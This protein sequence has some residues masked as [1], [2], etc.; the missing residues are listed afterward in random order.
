MDLRRGDWA[1]RVGWK[2]G[3][4]CCIDQSCIDL[5]E[6]GRFGELSAIIVE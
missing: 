6:I 3:C 1:A 4:R 5:G 2:G